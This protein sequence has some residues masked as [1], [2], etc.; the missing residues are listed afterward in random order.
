VFPCVVKDCLLLHSIGAQIVSFVSVSVPPGRRQRLPSVR[1]VEQWERR[2]TQSRSHDEVLRQNDFD[3]ECSTSRSFSS[4]LPV[5]VAEISC[6]R[7]TTWAPVASAR[8]RG[9]G[10]LFTC[11][12]TRSTRD[13]S[14]PSNLR[15]TVRVIWR[16]P[17]GG[18][19]LTVCS[20]RQGVRYITSGALVLTIVTILIAIVFI[21]VPFACTFVV[22]IFV[23]FVLRTVWT[24]AYL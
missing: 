3:S 9:V 6:P 14:V 21:C 8:V 2:R 16:A 17:H 7:R 11:V 20:S 24:V 18:A 4:A 1:C 5:Y 22:V 15:V 10:R 13:Q 23:S 19:K 12:S